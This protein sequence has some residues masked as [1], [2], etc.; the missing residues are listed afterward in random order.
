MEFEKKPRFVTFP[1]SVNEHLVSSEWCQHAFNLVYGILLYIQLEILGRIT[2]V[3]CT[4]C[5]LLLQMSH[6][7]WSVCLCV[8]LCVGHT[9]ERWA[10]R[11]SRPRCRFFWGGGA[12]SCEFKE[13]CVRWGPPDP[14]EKVHFW[15]RT[16]AGRLHGNVPTRCECACP[17]HVAN[18]SIRRREGWQEGDAAFCQ[19]TLDTG[20]NMSQNAKNTQKGVKR[21]NLQRYITE[22]FPITV[23]KKYDV[24]NRLQ[25]YRSRDRWRNGCRWRRVLCRLSSIRR[26]LRQSPPPP[27][28]SPSSRGSRSNFR[29]DLS[30]A[31]VWSTAGSIARSSLRCVRY[32]ICRQNVKILYIKS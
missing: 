14:D 9:G 15:G 28:P 10:K 26:L 17:A 13:P 20:S 24:A 1:L 12:D 22:C 5:G 2:C 25:T 27:S 31:D 3:Q 19:V 23:Y 32:S 6:I 11:L 21:I 4:S 7:A 18:E 29:H 30:A 16:Y 8:F